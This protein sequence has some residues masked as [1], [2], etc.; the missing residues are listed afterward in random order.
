MEEQTGAVGG[1]FFTALVLIVPMW[2]IFRRAGFHPPLSLL[3]F[4]PGFGFLV[5]VLLLALRRWP[6]VAQA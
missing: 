6:A 5:A 3:I 2:R 4:I 1:Y